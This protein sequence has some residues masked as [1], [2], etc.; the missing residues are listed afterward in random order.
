MEVNLVGVA[1]RSEAG[2]EKVDHNYSVSKSEA[3]DVMVVRKLAKA[4]T[5]C[6]FAVLQYC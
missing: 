1:I 6:V 3:G 4:S 5:H 2:A